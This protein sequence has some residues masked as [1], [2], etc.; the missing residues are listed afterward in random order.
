[1]LFILW[2]C[3]VFD[4]FSAAQVLVHFSS[5]NNI[6]DNEFIPYTIC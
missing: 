4:K 2:Y 3:V 1:M 5:L 6:K